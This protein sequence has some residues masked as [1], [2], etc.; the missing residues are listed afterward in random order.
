MI[1][2][3]NLDYQTGQGPL[4]SEDTDLYS[5][6]N[7]PLGRMVIKDEETPPLYDMVVAH[8]VIY[9]QPLPSKEE[10]LSLY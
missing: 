4:Y 7:I 1:Y 2:F 8:A 6:S 9:D 5:L 10:L 3:P